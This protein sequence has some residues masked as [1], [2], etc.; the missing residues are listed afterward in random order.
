MKSQLHQVDILPNAAGKN[1]NVS[2][3]SSGDG[4]TEQSL[5]LANIK[6]SESDMDESDEEG[7][8]ACYIP[9]FKEK[10]PTFL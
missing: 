5:P 4:M 7:M 8:V 2:A 6:M 3:D 1:N 10:T 9:S